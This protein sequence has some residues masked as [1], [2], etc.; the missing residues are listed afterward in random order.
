[1][2]LTHN[3]CLEIE[4][5]GQGLPDTNGKAKKLKLEGQPIDGN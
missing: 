4:Q 3:I 1:M 5:P 2:N